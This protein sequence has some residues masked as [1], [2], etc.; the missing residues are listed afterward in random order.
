M[1]KSKGLLKGCFEN[2]NIVLNILYGSC[3]DILK[4]TA[5][6]AITM[7]YMKDLNKP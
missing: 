1:Q 6:L 7:F 4:G 5:T 3:R 2:V